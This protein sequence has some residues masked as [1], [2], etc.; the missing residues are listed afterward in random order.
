M[1]QHQVDVGEPGGGEGAGD[2]G[3]GGGVGVCG[4]FGGE[5]EGGAREGRGEEGVAAGGFVAVGGGGV[6]LRVG[7]LVWWGWRW[8]RGEGSYVAV[9]GVE[10]VGDGCLGFGGGAGRGVS[11]WGLVGELGVVYICQTWEG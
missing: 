11:W 9:T 7:E 2:L 1:Q 8:G 4:D 10:G 5:E 6:D 3:F